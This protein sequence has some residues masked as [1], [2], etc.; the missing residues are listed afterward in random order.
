MQIAY[1]TCQCWRSEKLPVA[2][3]YSTFTLLGPMLDGSRPL[4][5]GLL[6]EFKTATLG[7]VTGNNGHDTSHLSRTHD[8]NL[9]R[10]PDV[11]EAR[12]IGAPTHA[13]I[14]RTV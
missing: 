9:R 10:W 3:G 13:E 4:G 14:S 11:G 5:I 1:T 6:I 8:G 2:N 7:R 12:R